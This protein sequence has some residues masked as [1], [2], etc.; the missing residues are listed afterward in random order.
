MKEKEQKGMTLKINLEILMKRS[1]GSFLVQM[2]WKLLLLKLNL[3]SSLRHQFMLPITLFYFL[4]D[5]IISNNRKRLCNKLW[6]IIVP[7]P[8]LK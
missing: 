4:T 3:K 1:I 5:S 2:I 7:T 6:M 8:P